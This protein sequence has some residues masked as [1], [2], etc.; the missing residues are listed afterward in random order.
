MHL[1]AANH[2]QNGMHF[3]AKKKKSAVDLLYTSEW[4]EFIVW[5]LCKNTKINTLACDTGWVHAAA[6]VIKSNN[7][8]KSGFRLYHVLASSS[9]HFAGWDELIL[10]PAT[11][12]R[13]GGCHNFK[14]E[15]LKT[16][17]FCSFRYFS[18]LL[19][20]LSFLFVKNSVLAPSWWR[21]EFGF[22]KT[23]CASGERLA[24]L[25]FRLRRTLAPSALDT[26]A[27]RSWLITHRPC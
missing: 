3:E 21:G 5:S 9:C 6:C 17:G 27:S 22:G 4:T 20:R 18:S 26:H 10:L 19:S 23:S 12:Y 13:L 7:K 15:I 8:C 1:C 16:Y 24:S 2:R 14:F 11:L 25:V